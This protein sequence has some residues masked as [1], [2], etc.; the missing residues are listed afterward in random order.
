MESHVSFM[1]SGP[2]IKKATKAGS[3]IS[4]DL[5]K[6]IPVNTPINVTCILGHVE[7]ST[8]EQFTGYCEICRLIS[9]I[10]RYDFGAECLHNE[11]TRGSS[12]PVM[13]ECTHK[14]KSIENM[15]KLSVKR[16]FGCKTCRCLARAKVYRADTVCVNAHVHSLIRFHC[17]AMYHDPK[18]TRPK[19]RPSTC[20]NVICCDRDFYASPHMLQEGGDITSCVRGHIWP[21]HTWEIFAAIRVFENL[22][23]CRFDDPAPIGIIVTG[24]NSKLGVAYTHKSDKVPK[25]HIDTAKQWCLD[26]KIVFIVI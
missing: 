4:P 9:F 7:H 5:M 13:I 10:K 16:G 6:Y 11:Y 24:Y 15:A 18:C 3:I 26:M 12:M 1:L 8:A 21:R 2:I 17:S 20:D 22:Y 25:K 14:H 19:C 23:D